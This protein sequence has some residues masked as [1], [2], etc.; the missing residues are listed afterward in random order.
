[1]M[2]RMLA[3][4]DAYAARVGALPMPEGYDSRAQVVRNTGARLLSNYPWLYGVLGG[5]LLVI[6]GVI[7]L[8]LRHLRALLRRRAAA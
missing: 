4:Y 6:G 3:E 1:M 5:I 2:Q 8:A 7:W